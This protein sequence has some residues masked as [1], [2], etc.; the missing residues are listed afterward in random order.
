MP[1][2]LDAQGNSNPKAFARLTPE[3]YA[4]ATQIGVDNALMLAGAARGPSFATS[5]EEVHAYTFATVIGG[6]NRLG[7]DAARGVSAPDSRSYGFLGGIGVGDKR[8]NAGAFGGYLNNRQ[9]IDTLDAATRAEGFVAGVQA[10]FAADNGFGVN[11]AIFYTG[12]KAR[13]GRSL[14]GGFDARGRYDLDSWVT[15]V[16]VSYGVD[17]M[18]DWAVR[19]HAGLTYV[20]T[21]R[22]DLEEAGGS[23][24]ALT[25]ARDRHVAGFADTGIHFGRSA[26]SIAAFR[27]FVSLGA[28]YQIEGRRADALAGYS[29]AGLG[30]VAVGA[31]R[32]SLVGTVAAGI[33]CRLTETLGIFATA[34][35]QTGRD[36][37]QETVS[38]GVRMRF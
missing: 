30:L 23:P 33:D 28:R 26:A 2:L 37:H 13:T 12:S 15:D 38:A 7:D 22:G 4:S 32:A 25:V 6:W 19:P 17:V 10:R 3:P 24:F 8:W 11:A 29:G 16:S 27:P 1:T 31:Q 36:D 20:R 34:A 18:S 35:S 5:G 21:T 9:S 14:A